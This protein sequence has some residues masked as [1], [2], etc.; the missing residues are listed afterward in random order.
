MNIALSWPLQTTWKV[1]KKVL[2]SPSKPLYPLEQS[3]KQ[4]HHPLRPPLRGP[5]S[6][7]M[8]VDSP[9]MDEVAQRVFEAFHEEKFQAEVESFILTHFEELPRHAKE[10]GDERGNI[11]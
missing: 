9:S 1:F 8:D 2:T 3:T 7:A 11:W 6:F 10:K 4:K 5:P